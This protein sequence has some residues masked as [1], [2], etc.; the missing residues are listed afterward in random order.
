[1]WENNGTAARSDQR[2]LQIAK[3]RLEPQVE[4]P[5]WKKTLES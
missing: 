4:D 1:M 5:K 2:G 3:R